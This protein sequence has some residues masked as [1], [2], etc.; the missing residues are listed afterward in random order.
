MI[1]ALDA[2]MGRIMQVLDEWGIAE[3]TII[4]F[5]SDHGDHLSS[6]GYGKP[7]AADAW[8]HHTLR[9]SKG[10]PHEEAVHIPFILR[11]PSRVP[12]NRRSTTLFNSVD[13]M[14]TLLA[15]CGVTIP[16]GVQG[17]DLSHAALGIAGERPDSVY[18]QMLGPGWPNR[19]K[20][21]G[22][23]RGVRTHRYVYARWHDL[24][25]RR[26]LYDRAA[27]PLEMQ[28]GVDDPEYANVAAQLETRLRGWIEETKDPFETGKRLPVT[29]MLDVGQALTTL[30]MHQIVP[31]EYLAAIEKNHLNVRTGEQS[32]SRVGDAT[33]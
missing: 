13:V 27:D 29:G 19:T 31:R 30:A 4:C 23:W 7:G 24:G 11:Y 20:T 26:M 2:S 32:G 25:G 17:K 12:G 21:V 6:H 28:N 10:T 1:T 15:L 9:L 5:S 14:P 16:E 3:N 33:A 22:L 8:M 18:L